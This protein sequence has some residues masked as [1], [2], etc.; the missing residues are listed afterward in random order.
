MLA[1]RSAALA[2]RAQRDF[3]AWSLAFAGVG[4]AFFLAVLLLAG[5]SPLD[6]SAWAAIGQV[7]AF[8]FGLAVAFAGSFV[9]VRLAAAALRISDEAQQMTAR[10]FELDL[11]GRVAGE[12]QAVLGDLRA[13]AAALHTW[14]LA[15][16]LLM[17]VI[18]DA[19][20]A[21][22]S[23]P[24]GAAR[25]GALGA[26]LAPQ[27]DAVRNGLRSVSDAL[28]QVQ[29]HEGSRRALE[30]G[31]RAAA[32]ALGAEPRALEDCADDFHRMARS[33]AANRAAAGLLGVLRPP[34]ET[35]AEAHFSALE[36]ILTFGPGT[37][38][39]P[40][41]E[42]GMRLVLAQMRLGVAAFACPEVV[43]AAYD[44]GRAAVLQPLGAVAQLMLALPRPEV[45]REALTR[46]LAKRGFEAGQ[47][48]LAALVTSELGGVDLRLAVPAVARL[49][50]EHAVRDAPGGPAVTI[51][52]SGR[53][54]LER[55]LD[56]LGG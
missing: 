3:L 10:R 47:T 38:E 55:L 50:A 18:P 21:T 2:Q 6:G 52:A 8:V 5:G 43:D 53:T 48:E 16:D 29:V 30:R 19:M 45:L 20:A 17:L 49:A 12:V 44:A 4:A 26:A 15:T 11:R 51:V 28:L 40:A 37:P 46:D 9:A 35:D 39:T 31:M 54:R 41:R 33:L 24:P 56:P 23:Q 36:R 34:A 32:D 42:R 25:R 13:L 27:L 14:W 22:W 1:D 7:G